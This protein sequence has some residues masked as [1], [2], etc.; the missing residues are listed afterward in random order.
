[1]PE[2]SDSRQNRV[3]VISFSTPEG[4]TTQAYCPENENFMLNYQQRLSEEG[5]TILK[6]DFA[7][8]KGDLPYIADVLGK[9]ADV[10]LARGKEEAKA[11]LPTA[12]PAL[13]KIEAN[14]RARAEAVKKPAP[15]TPTPPSVDVKAATSAP[16]ENPR[17]TADRTAD[18]STIASAT[19]QGLSDEMYGKLQEYRESERSWL[20][21]ASAPLKLT[22]GLFVAPKVYTE[23]FNYLLV[24]GGLISILLLIMATFAGIGIV[25]FGH[26]TNP[27]IFKSLGLTPFFAV[28]PLSTYISFDLS[29][30]A[31][32]LIDHLGTIVV[33]TVIFTLVLSFFGVAQHI[34]MTFLFIGI[35]R[36]FINF[37]GWGM[38]LFGESISEVSLIL[39]VLFFSIYVAWKLARAFGYRSEHYQLPLSILMFFLFISCTI[40]MITNGD[41]W[42]QIKSSVLGGHDNFG[43]ASTAVIIAQFAQ[44]ESGRKLVSAVLRASVALQGTGITS[45]SSDG[46]ELDDENLEAYLSRLDAQNKDKPHSDLLDVIQSSNKSGAEIDPRDLFK[47]ADLMQKEEIRFKDAG[48]EGRS[49]GKRGVKG[50]LAAAGVAG[51]AKDSAEASGEAFEIE[52][53]W[54]KAAGLIRG[55]SAGEN[56]RDLDFSL[57]LFRMTRLENPDVP[58]GKLYVQ[59]DYHFDGK[60]FK[61][62]E[63]VEISVP[64]SH[65]WNEPGAYVVAARVREQFG[66]LSQ[67]IIHRVLIGKKK[68]RAIPQKRVILSPSLDLIPISWSI[69]PG[70]EKPEA[71]SLEIDLNPKAVFEA[72]LALSGTTSYEF[73]PA[74]KG[75]TTIKARALADEASIGPAEALVVYVGSKAIKSFVRKQGPFLIGE[76]SELFCIPEKG[77]AAYEW[78]FSGRKDAFGTPDQS[79]PDCRLEHVFEKGGLQT[80]VY[81]AVHPSGKKGKPK[82]LTVKV[83]DFH[84]ESALVVFPKWKGADVEEVELAGKCFSFGEIAVDVNMQ[85]DPEYK[86]RSFSAKIKGADKK[87]I[88]VK[89]TDRKGLGVAFRCVDQNGE[90]GEPTVHYFVE[91]FQYIPV[92]ITLG[93][94]LDEVKHYYEVIPLSQWLDL[95]EKDQSRY[96]PLFKPGESLARPEII[97]HLVRWR[98]LI[99]GEKMSVEQKRKKLLQHIE[100]HPE[101]LMAFSSETGEKSDSDAKEV[102]KTDEDKT[103]LVINRF[104]NMHHSPP[105]K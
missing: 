40:P 17:S 83:K 54:L 5:F 37:F 42:R 79:T 85:W 15:K 64:V 12:A 57:R 9:G 102:V 34:L 73:K 16:A 31:W 52:R 41:A 19:G 59:W 104:I 20:D 69:L 95:P 67:A 43:N 94:S 68:H 92:D 25:I 6:V 28:I 90:A 65:S 22:F 4:V 30:A 101:L 91:H 14:E 3:V 27:E 105:V 98:Q 99:E 1:M 35:A 86:G 38:S 44:S 96:R 2:N 56:G 87:S 89:R 74:K 26:V 93:V 75:K 55:P 18:I 11:E 76:K 82:I 7:N 103:L 50:S 81:R 8:D 23:Q 21:M 53:P 63:E 62:S 36:M 24:Y 60:N 33:L 80:I 97:K 47:L 84:L 29:S 88:T 32:L 49:P 58:Y 71:F 10:P 61:D 77:A 39:I 46:S 70:D 72:D 78:S 48:E 66:G 100:R 45:T 13:K 51:A